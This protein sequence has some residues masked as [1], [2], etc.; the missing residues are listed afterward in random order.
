MIEFETEVPYFYEYI[1]QMIKDTGK[2]G[3]IMSTAFIKDIIQE[4]NETFDN[5]EIVIQ[6]WIKYWDLHFS[7]YLNSI[8]KEN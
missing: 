6:K 4:T 2:V 7:L 3:L 5:M 8:E 1:Y